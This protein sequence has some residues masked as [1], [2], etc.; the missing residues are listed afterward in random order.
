MA[1][2]KQIS[3]LLM[4]AC[5]C[6]VAN[7]CYPRGNGRPR[8]DDDDGDWHWYED[9]HDQSGDGRFINCGA[10]DGNQAHAKCQDGY[11]LPVVRS[12]AELEDIQAFIG[13][14]SK[15]PIQ[16]IKGCLVHIAM[17]IAISRTVYYTKTC[18][19][20]MHH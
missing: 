8:D 14:D 16:T 19:L 17:H 12:Q 1:L 9:C 3:I 20:K 7:G 2:S 11:E 18:A 10:M 15:D 4:L 6:L 13:A 5:V